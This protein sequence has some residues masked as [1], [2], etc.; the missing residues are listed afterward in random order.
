MRFNLIILVVVL[1]FALGGCE[2]K[3]EQTNSTGSTPA[4]LDSPTPQP[5]SSPAPE[6]TTN[7]MPS[8]SPTPVAEHPGK[9][10]TQASVPEPAREIAVPTGVPSPRVGISTPINTNKPGGPRRDVYADRPVNTNKPGGP[11]S[12]RG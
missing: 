8:S 3:V 9:K 6:V 7:P 12:R 11:R 4:T 2:G 1:T 5:A 10:G